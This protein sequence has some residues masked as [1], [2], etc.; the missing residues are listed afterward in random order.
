[1]DHF[2]RSGYS[3]CRHTIKSLNEAVNCWSRES[4]VIL[5]LILMS[6]LDINVI[7]VE[8]L[9]NF[10]EFCALRGQLDEARGRID[11]LESSLSRATQEGDAWRAQVD[12]GTSHR[13][14][15]DKRLK[16]TE[17]NLASATK[18]NFVLF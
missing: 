16:I 4:L 11:G 18:R 17:E 12:E 10:V 3:S 2:F 1:M 5:L 6:L 8:F 9:F 13:G 15:T 14:T 7:F